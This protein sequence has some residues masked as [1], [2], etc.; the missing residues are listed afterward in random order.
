MIINE[1]Y[2]KQYSPIPLNYNMAEVKNYIPVAEKI[3][4]KPLI[5]SDLFDEIDDQVANNTVS[6][7]NATLLTEG[8]LWQYLAFATVYEALPMIW[9]HISEVGVTK[10]KSDNSDSLDLKD[11]TWVTQHL[12]NQVEVLKDQLKKWI[13]EHQ[14]SFPLADVCACNCSSCCNHE[15]KLNHPNPQAQIYTTLRLNTKLK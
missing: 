3:W 12:R 9:S 14:D 10:G 2:I 8:G 13:C 5:G 1:K 4:V 11:M 7:E 6:Q 15:A